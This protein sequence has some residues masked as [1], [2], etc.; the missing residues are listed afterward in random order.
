MKSL[1]STYKNLHKAY[2]PQGWWP[3]INSKTLMCE[4]H[5]KDYDFPRTDAERFEIAISAILAQNTNWYPNVV[6]G[7]QQLTLGRPFTKDELKLIEYAEW[8]HHK[9]FRD[10]GLKVDSPFSRYTKNRKEVL[11]AGI[12]D[13]LAKNISRKGK[14][15]TKDN[16]FTQNTSWKNVEKAIINL[17]KAKLISIDKLDKIPEKKLAELIRPSGYYNQKAKKLKA[18][19]LF[20]KTNP[21]PKLKK[22]PTDKLRHM[23]LAVHGIGPETADSILLYALGRPVFVVDAYTRRVFPKMR[24]KSYSEIQDFFHKSLNKETGLFQEYHALIVE[25]AKNVHPK[26]IR[27]G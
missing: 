1:I 23:L 11:E 22:I 3:I 14:V 26:K 10:K 27:T 24:D 15:I 17:N 13:I 16:I 19:V 18:L 21:L 9:T 6:R 2:G 7:M 25:H 12:S 4:Y 8:L 20:L 5:P